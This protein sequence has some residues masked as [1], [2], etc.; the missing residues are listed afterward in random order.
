MIVKFLLF[1][2]ALTLFFTL[3]EIEDFRR[4][5]NRVVETQGCK[6]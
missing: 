4:D 2:V 1:F 5:F 6:K 3:V